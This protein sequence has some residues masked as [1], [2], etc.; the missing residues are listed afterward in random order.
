[1][2]QFSLH[3]CPPLSNQIFG[4][5]AT[6]STA[7]ILCNTILQGY[8]SLMYYRVGSTKFVIVQCRKITIHIETKTV[9]YTLCKDYQIKLN[10]TSKSCNKIVIKIY[11]SEPRNTTMDHKVKY[12]KLQVL[13][14]LYSQS[15]I[16]PRMSASVTHNFGLNNLTNIMNSIM[17]SE[18]FR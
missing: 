12:N 8:T 5:Y 6:K 2:W 13:V 10:D 14:K 15:W 17:T 9:R 18:K 3:T 11:G 7:K 16:R 4:R 1:M